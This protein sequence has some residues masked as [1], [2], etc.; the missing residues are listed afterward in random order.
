MA[1][2]SVNADRAS[3]HPN[4]CMDALPVDADRARLQP[5]S[6]WLH[7]CMAA[8]PVGAGF[9][10]A[11]SQTV[12]GC[13][14]ALAALPVDADRGSLHPNAY[15]KCAVMHAGDPERRMSN[16]LTGACLLYTSPS[17]RDAHES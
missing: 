8:S 14:A 5:N 10:Q 3:L 13:I 12:H 16:E 6:A 4:A 9:A 2:F 11:C 7:R 15:V 17:P 1:A